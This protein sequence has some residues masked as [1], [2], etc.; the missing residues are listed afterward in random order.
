MRRSTLLVACASRVLL[1]AHRPPCARLRVCGCPCMRE[2][3]CA[4]AEMRASVRVLP[5]ALVPAGAG[6]CT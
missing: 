4:L 5:A 6:E 2:R 3:V 1:S